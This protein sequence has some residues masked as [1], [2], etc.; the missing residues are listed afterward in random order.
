[1]SSEGVVDARGG[2]GSARER[3]AVSFG[4]GG[5]YDVVLGVLDR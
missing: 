1:M 3:V 5:E 4:K 2:S